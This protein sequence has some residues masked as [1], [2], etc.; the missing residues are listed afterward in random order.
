MKAL[1][2]KIETKWKWIENNLEKTLKIH[3]WNIGL[4]TTT[5]NYI[6]WEWT[7]EK[8]EI[9]KTHQWHNWVYCNNFEITLKGNGQNKIWKKNL[10]IH[11]WN[12]WKYCN[13]LKMSMEKTLQDSP[14]KQFSLL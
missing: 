2:K 14:M 3:Q 4:I 10:K 12:D 7:K 1:W 6:E 5:Q 13:N 11:R 9:L 8:L